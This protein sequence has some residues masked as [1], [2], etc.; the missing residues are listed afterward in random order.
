METPPRTPPQTPPRTS[1]QTPPR[2]S[3]GTPLAYSASSASLR[4]GRSAPPR[5]P[6]RLKKKGDPRRVEVKN[7][8]NLK[9]L[10]ILKNELKNKRKN[11]HALV[12]DF[13]HTLARRHFYSVIS[14]W[15]KNDVP[16][17]YVKQDPGIDT[18]DV[19]KKTQERL[20]FVTNNA[21]FITWIFGGKI[22]VI[23]RKK[24]KERLYYTINSLK[25][26]LN[27]FDLYIATNGVIGWVRKLLDSLGIINSDWDRFSSIFTSIYGWNSYDDRESHKDPVVYITSID[28]SVETVKGKGEFIKL[29]GKMYNHVIY[30]DDQDGKEGYETLKNIRNIDRIDMTIP[31]KNEPYEGLQKSHWIQIRRYKGPVR[32][33]GMDTPL[34]H[35]VGACISSSSLICQVCGSTPVKRCG[36]CKR[37]NYC[38]F[39][40]QVKHWD[41][42]HK[43]ECN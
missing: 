11:S 36:G 1:P 37:I 12:L 26:L 10:K 40:C 15:L 21:E 27:T 34:R 24:D 29:L 39:E 41:E 38:G 6:P 18:E 20:K 28:N 32:G 16:E 5:S 19:N 14:D 25:K 2:T 8:K 43:Y 30:A 3:Q 42:S 22:K 9:K 4:S 33:D 35:G 13:D 31:G 17:I 7:L 23:D